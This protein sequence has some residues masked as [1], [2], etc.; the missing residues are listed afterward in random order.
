MRFRFFLTSLFSLHS[1]H[2][3][4]LASLFALGGCRT[5][6]W[7]EMEV[8]AYCNCGECCSWTRGSWLFLKLDFW[9][10]RISTGPNKGKPY[11]GLTSSGTKPHAPRP[12]LV[13]TDSLVHP[14]M[15]PVRIVFPWLILPRSGTIAA[16]TNYYP[17]GTEIYV[18]GWGW[19]VVEDRGSAIKGP[20]R[21]DV[22][23]S[24]HRRALKFGRQKVETTILRDE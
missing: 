18:P 19:G 2:I 3:I 17:F 13:S 10:K 23:I 16:D 6:E 20:D 9:N 8:T 1:F 21:L 24:S 15:I 12:G 22:Y 5:A 11:S 7:R 14:W 4:L